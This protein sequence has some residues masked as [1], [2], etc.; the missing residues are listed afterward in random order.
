M[1]RW[2]DRKSKTKDW[3]PFDEGE[4]FLDLYPFIFSREDLE[5]SFESSQALEDFLMEIAPQSFCYVWRYA[6]SSNPVFVHGNLIEMVVAVQEDVA[7]ILKI[8]TGLQPIDNSTYQLIIHG[9]EKYW[10]MIDV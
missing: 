6:K 5:L 4:Q 1:F 9:D 10:R 7:M 2:R 3:S 8:K